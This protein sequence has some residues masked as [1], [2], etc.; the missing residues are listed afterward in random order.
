MLSVGHVGIGMGRG[1]LSDRI[2]VY[3][4]ILPR[5]RSVL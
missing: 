5:C 2:R 3:A 1:S 4:R